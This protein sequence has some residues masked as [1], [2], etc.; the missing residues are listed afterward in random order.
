M[1]QAIVTATAPV[2][3]K[4]QRTV[5]IAQVVVEGREHSQETR[6]D[7]PFSATLVDHQG[8]AEAEHDGDGI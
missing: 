2:P 5:S 3:A 4:L 8:R 1:N 6:L 7:T